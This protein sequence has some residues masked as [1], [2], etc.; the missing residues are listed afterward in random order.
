MSCSNLSRNETRSYT[1]MEVG[2]EKPE[3]DNASGMEKQI[4]PESREHWAKK[5]DFLLSVIGFAIDL[6]NV[7]RFPY[8]CFKNGGGAFF[9]PYLL[10]LFFGG[11][12]LF[13]M[14]LALGQYACEGA[15]TCWGKVCPLFKGL[16][17]SVVLIAF[18]T[19]LFY[20]IIIAWALFYFFSSF[21]YKLPWVSCDNSW[22]TVNCSIA[23]L[24]DRSNDTSLQF[25]SSITF[26]S[27]EFYI[28]EVLGLTSE[29]SI[30]NLGSVQWKT[31]V[32][33]LIIDLICFLSL[34]KGIKTSGKVVWFT[35]IFPYVVL[36]I[37]LVR[38]LTL[39][40]SMDG[41]IY[42]LK[43]DLSKL[44]ALLVSAVNSATSFLS[45][46]V[47][48]SVLGYMAMKRGV[49]LE[50]VINEGWFKRMTNSVVLCIEDAGMVFKVYPEALATFPFPQFWSVMFFLMLLTLGLDSSFG[51]SEAIITA[52]CDEY[53]V[54]KRHRGW[55]VL[56]LFSFYG[57]VGV[58]ETTQGGFYIFN[59][60]Q[61]TSVNYSILFAVLIETVCV[62][63]IFGVD[64]F[65][66]AIDQMIGFKPSI[67]WKV[68]WKFVSPCFILVSFVLFSHVFFKFNLIC[69]LIAHQNLTYGAYVYPPWANAVGWVLSLSSVLVV[70]LVAIIKIIRDRRG[71]ISEVCYIS[72][73]LIQ[74]LSE[75]KEFT[76][77]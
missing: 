50:K 62:S 1:A 25:N 18:Y 48:F 54:L 59:L 5:A 20:N 13:Y 33:F 61:S 56:V 2:S 6:A 12:P 29:I 8:L 4:L 73:F 38:G 15:I 39:E 65:R 75:N 7:W 42:Y 63:W 49:S 3:Q 64:K 45:G 10:M 19:D 31:A 77:H 35:A 51:G 36:F 11:I 55:F 34:F 26:P 76:C 60:L 22:N 69:G 58:L 37:L 52:L 21:N 23:H 14:E 43:P 70:P 71:P 28:K 46:F 47:I 66:E 57:I 27:E 72:Q 41:L 74:L 30:E 67:Y 40:G 68:C 24:Q 44:D 53:P 17:Y 32:S 9:I 16:G